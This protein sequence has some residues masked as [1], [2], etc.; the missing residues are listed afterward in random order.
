[1]K[2]PDAVVLAVNSVLATSPAAGGA[3]K[4]GLVSAVWLARQKKRNVYN[5]VVVAEFGDGCLATVWRRRTVLSRAG[6]GVGRAL[7]V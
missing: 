3:Q 4:G 6:A 5:V 1:M 7:R 2:V